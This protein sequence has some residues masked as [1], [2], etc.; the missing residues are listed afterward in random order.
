[1]VLSE[2]DKMADSVGFEVKNFSGFFDVLGGINFSGVDC[3]GDV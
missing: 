3:C 2:V 1:M